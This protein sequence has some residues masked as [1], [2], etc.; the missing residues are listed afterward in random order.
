[1][2]V[3]MQAL[4]AEV[5]RGDELAWE[6]F[7]RTHQGRVFGLAYHYV[8]QAEDARDVAQDAFVRVYQHL[9]EIPDEPGLIPWLLAITRNLSIDHLRRRKARPPVWDLPIEDFKHLRA[10]EEGPEEAELRASRKGRVHRALQE[11]SELNREIILLKE[12]QGLGLEEIAGM[13]GVPLGTVKSRSNR[14]RLE[15]A[16]KL[17]AL[18]GL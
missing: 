12:I 4:L 10:S 8:G 18:G 9:A 7:I 3:E 16:E 11:L 1:M 5:R 15:L 6:A 17:V 2:T 13:L 14:A